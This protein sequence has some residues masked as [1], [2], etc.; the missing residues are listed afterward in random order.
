MCGIPCFIMS[1]YI[2]ITVFIACDILCLDAYLILIIV[3]I[4][5]AML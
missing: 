2:D 4:F 1:V 3:M 5:S